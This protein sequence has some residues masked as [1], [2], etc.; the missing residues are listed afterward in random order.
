MKKILEVNNLTKTYETASG[1]LEIL[2]AVSFDVNFA[3]SIAITGPSGSG[4]TTLL[5]LISGLDKP[6]SGQI[7]ISDQS[8]TDMSEQEVENFRS[9]NIG[10]IFQ[11][12]HLLPQ[13]TAIENVLLPTLPTKENQDTA[14][15]RALELLE[16]VGLSQRA[17]HF[18]A[19]LSG[20]EQL[21]VAIARAMINKPLIILADEP[22]GFLD[23]SR[24]KEIIELLAS[25]EGQTLITVTHAE[26]VASA[27]KKQLRLVEG[28]I[29]D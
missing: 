4:K 5:N 15:E 2:K 26:Y 25:I 11:H 14:S 23:Q 6:D 8:L 10:I 12:H 1:K 13:C 20:G 21:R 24:G 18:P 7:K 9:E 17:G 22:T 28:E 16:R 29:T 3:D 27:M 19:Q